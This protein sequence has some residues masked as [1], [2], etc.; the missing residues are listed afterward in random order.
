MVM[1]WIVGRLDGTYEECSMYDSK[2]S[3]RQARWTVRNQAID[4]SSLFV[5]KFLHRSTLLT[6]SCQNMTRGTSPG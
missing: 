4:L 3:Y 2:Y 1:Y 6:K 5:T